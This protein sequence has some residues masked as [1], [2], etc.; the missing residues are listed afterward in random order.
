MALKRGHFLAFA[1]SLVEQEWESIL[2]QDS[3]FM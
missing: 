1:S 3:E 2:R